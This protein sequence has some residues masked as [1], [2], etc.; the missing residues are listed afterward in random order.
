MKINKKKL[1]DKISNLKSR[2]SVPVNY[3]GKAE[4]SLKLSI[5]EDI[6]EC[7]EYEGDA[8]GQGG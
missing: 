4:D 7:C 2:L 5:L 6:D 3:D 8:G 1:Q